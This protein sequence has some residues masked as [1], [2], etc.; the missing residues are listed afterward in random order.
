MGPCMASKYIH[1]YSPGSSLV[2]CLESI[3]WSLHLQGRSL[4]PP[5]P[6]PLDSSAILQQNPR[7]L[8]QHR[9]QSSDFG[10][11]SSCTAS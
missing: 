2:A 7:T 1:I 3:S 6:P 5:Y 4:P 11:Q 9:S 10:G 8:I